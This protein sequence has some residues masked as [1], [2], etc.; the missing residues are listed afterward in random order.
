MSYFS[1]DK[2]DVKEGVV[3]DGEAEEGQVE[4]DDEMKSTIEIQS[5]ENRQVDIPAFALLSM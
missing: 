5:S 1:R 2:E 4:N 3:G